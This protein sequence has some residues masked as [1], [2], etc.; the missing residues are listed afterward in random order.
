MKKRNIAA[1]LLS[2]L[3]LVGMAAGCGPK[4][5][6]E[7]PATGSDAAT[8]KAAPEAAADDVIRI[9]FVGPLTGDSAAWGIA[10]KNAIEIR[11]AKQNE[12]GGL[13]GKQIKLFSYDNREDPVESVNAARKLIEQDKVVAILGP[14]NSICGQA[15]NTV[16]E[17]YKIPML[18][19][20]TTLETV[21]VD[22]DGNARPYAFRAIMVERAYVKSVVDYMYDKV[23]ARTAA[24][25][26]ILSNETNVVM[27]NTFDELW[28]AK[29]GQVV[30]SE[31]TASA[32]DVDFRAQLT[33]IKDLNPDIIFSPFTY[34]QIILMGQQARELGITSQFCGCDTWFQVNIPKSAGEQLEGCVAI[35]SLDV[36]SPVLDPIKAEYKEFFGEDQTLLD[37]GTDPYYGY[38]A[39]MMLKKAIEDKGAYDS[40]SIRDGLENLKDV[41]G[42][43]GS[44]SMDPAT[45]NPT[46]ELAIVTIKKQADGSYAYETLG[47]VFGDTITLK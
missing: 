16:V 35:A 44:L 34:K 25:L 26:Y 27:V 38:D 4:P 46:R 17:E 12:A 22:D 43:V 42:C 11:V 6:E 32:D 2:S 41:Q 18:C 30:A 37:G 23:G 39:F 28:K 13:L 40:A 10:Q 1:L 20:N 15:M 47:T 21:T 33:K 8:E 19:T 7:K 24:C 45:H 14:N 9:G 5:A 29:G 31:T 36:S 3:L